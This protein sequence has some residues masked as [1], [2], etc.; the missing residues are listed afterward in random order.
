MA[1]LD[2]Y[3]VLILDNLS[4]SALNLPVNRKSSQSCASFHQRG[5]KHEHKVPSGNSG[6]T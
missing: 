3:R 1:T 5:E 2:I 6:R 4:G